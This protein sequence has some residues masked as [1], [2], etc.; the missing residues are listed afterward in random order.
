MGFGLVV[1][2][3]KDVVE[4]FVDFFDYDVVL[5]GLKVCEV[6]VNFL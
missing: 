5:V 2:C 6:L 4:I 3:D 1:F